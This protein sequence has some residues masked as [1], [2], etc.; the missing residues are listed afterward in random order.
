MGQTPEKNGENTVI[1]EIRN[2]N[3]LNGTWIIGGFFKEIDYGTIKDLKVIKVLKGEHS[4]IFVILSTYFT[5]AEIQVIERFVE[6]LLSGTSLELIKNEKF[7]HSVL[8]PFKRIA[9]YI[10]K[11]QNAI[12]S[13]KVNDKEILQTEMNDAI[14][15]ALLR[16]DRDELEDKR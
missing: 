6:G 13:A 16:E 15:E 9:Q 5:H 3:L 7:R 2:A 12:I 10:A 8:S 14:R 1:I 4:I 11:D